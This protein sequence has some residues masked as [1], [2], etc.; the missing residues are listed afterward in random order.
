M[1]ENTER[2]ARDLFST[3]GRTTRNIKFYFRRGDNTAEQLSDYRTRAIA[4]IVNG[5]A[6]EDVDFDRHLLD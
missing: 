4:Q 2:V 1:T 3:V 6:D 5:M